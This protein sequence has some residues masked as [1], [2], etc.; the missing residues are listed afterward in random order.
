MKKCRG[1]VMKVSV[2]IPTLNAQKYLPELLQ[3]LS[4]QSFSFELIIIDSSSTDNTVQIAKQ[5]TDN[6]II[7]PHETFDHGKTRTQAAKIAN[8]DIIVFLTQDALPYDTKSIETLIKPFHN[9]AIAAVY[10]RQ[11]PHKEA[12]L[13]AEH[14]RLF[15]YP[16]ESHQRTIE[17]KTYFG[18]KT[19]FLSNSFTAYRRDVLKSIGW[20]KDG[21]IL[22]E[23]VHVGA[24]MLLSGCTLG[25]SADAK[26]YHSHNYSLMEEFKRYV[27]IGV[28]HAQE[29]WLLKEFGK[30]EREGSRYIRSEWKMLLQ[31]HKYPLILEFFLRNILKYSGYKLGKYNAFIPQHILKH[32]SMH[33]YWWKR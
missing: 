25:Y 5:Y 18:I 27:D 2:I 3:N 24:K 15:N 16:K 10:G 32:L 29:K 9:P 21:L 4:K 12:S 30:A 33:P 17:D 1:S 6:L 14:L 19:A 8:G 20:F 31:Q 28:F 23:D 11:I 13:F 22:G 26:V 7:I